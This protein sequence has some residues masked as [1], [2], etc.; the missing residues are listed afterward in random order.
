MRRGGKDP[1]GVGVSVARSEGSGRS[2]ARQAG[3]C[4]AGVVPGLSLC[5]LV[6]VEYDLFAPGGLGHL[7]HARWLGQVIFSLFFLFL[8]SNFLHLF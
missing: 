7:Y 4:T 3:G 2:T 5:L 1:G 8:F 6:E